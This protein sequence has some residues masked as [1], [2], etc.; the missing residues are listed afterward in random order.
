MVKNVES[1]PT[2]LLHKLTVG[3]QT[4]RCHQGRDRAP[5]RGVDGETGMEQ[6]TSARD[7]G[8]NGRVN[9]I[10]DLGNSESQNTR[11][12]PAGCRDERVHGVEPTAA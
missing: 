8:A 2:D 3:A 5:F 10:F 6:K 7:V 11:T 9:A 12:A 4:T 1:S